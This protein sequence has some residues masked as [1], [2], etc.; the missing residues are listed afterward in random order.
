MNIKAHSFANRQLEDELKSTV[1]RMEGVLPFWVNGIRLMYGG[2]GD[3]PDVCANVQ[4][5][6]EYREMA[7][8][9]YDSY[10]GLD[11]GDR[12]VVLMHEMCHAMVARV[13]EWVEDRVLPLIQEQNIQL[14]QF[15]AGELSS[16]VESTV[17]D[18]ALTLVKKT[19][20]DR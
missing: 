1:E 15:I 18:L 17:Q 5:L 8:Q 2:P 9:V 4:M 11:L 7:V 20:L 19:M 13:S 16:R 10:F 6:P 3:D 12:L 14:A